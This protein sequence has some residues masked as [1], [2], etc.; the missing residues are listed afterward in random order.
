MFIAPAPSGTGNKATAAPKAP[1][2]P[3]SASRNPTRRP[4]WR[5]CTSDEKWT[6][7]NGATPSISA[8]TPTTATSSSNTARRTNPCSHSRTRNE[9]PQTGTPGDSRELPRAGAIRV[10][11]YGDHFHHRLPGHTASVPDRREPEPR[12]AALAGRSSISFPHFNPLV[13]MVSGVVH[14]APVN[15]HS[16][17]L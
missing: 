11:S 12:C 6:S 3:S 2:A 8:G 15:A 10:R 1:P 13:G 5:C 4:C 16:C 7:R 14:D 9:S 17:S